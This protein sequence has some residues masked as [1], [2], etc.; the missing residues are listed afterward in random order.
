MTV[1]KPASRKFVAVKVQW[2]TICVCVPDRF[3]EVRLELFSIPTSFDV[4]TVM[5]FRFKVFMEG[6]ST[7]EYP[8]EWFHKSS[9]TSLLVLHIFS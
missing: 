1:L 9:F 6:C 3:K 7:I 4:L 8:T 2:F 5:L